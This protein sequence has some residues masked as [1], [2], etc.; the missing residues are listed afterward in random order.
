M[1]NEPIMICHGNHVTITFAPKIY[2]YHQSNVKDSV[3]M[4]QCECDRVSLYRYIATSSVKDKFWGSETNQIIIGLDSGV[5]AANV[6]L[7]ICYTVVVLFCCSYCSMCD[8]PHIYWSIITYGTH[9]KG[10]FLSTHSLPFILHVQLQEKG[11]LY[12]FQQQNICQY[13]LRIFLQ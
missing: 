3:W 12:L 4:W 6:L 13:W 9:R 1:K 10:W 8:S 2:E 7:M 11:F 5:T